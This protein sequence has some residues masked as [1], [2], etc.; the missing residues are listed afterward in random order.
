M[1]SPKCGVCVDFHQWEGVF[2]V[3]WGSSTDL[4]KVVTH[5]VAANRSSHMASRPMSLAST[6]FLHRHSLSHLV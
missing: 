6:D 4:A 5:Q 2:I 3:P 1:E